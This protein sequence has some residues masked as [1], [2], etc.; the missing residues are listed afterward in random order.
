MGTM[1]MRLLVCVTTMLLAGTAWAQGFD[2][3]QCAVCPPQFCSP[4]APNLLVYECEGGAEPHFVL[5]DGTL[6]ITSSG[7]NASF[8]VAGLTVHTT[9]GNKTFDPFTIGSSANRIRFT[10]SNGGE[11]VAVK[12]FSGYNDPSPIVVTEAGTGTMRALDVLQ[13]GTFYCREPGRDFIC[14]QVKGD[15]KGPFPPLACTGDADRI[16]YACGLVS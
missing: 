5:G 6:L 2:C 14:F 15:V 9:I 1:R 3:G 7:V 10:T 16:E 12:N 8:S 11:C 13:K 4:P